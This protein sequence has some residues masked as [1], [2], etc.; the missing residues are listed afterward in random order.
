[1]STC[2]LCDKEKKLLKK[3][4]IISDFFYRQGNLYDGHHKLN[5]I[6]VLNFF[7]GVFKFSRQS[8]GEYDKN[9]LCKECDGVVIKQYEDYTRKALY[10]GSL[11]DSENPKFKNIKQEGGVGFTSICD[12]NYNKF[13]LCI[14]S[15]L[16]RAHHSKREFFKDI[17]LTDIQEKQIKQY[18]KTGK[19]S[20]D[21]EWS[22]ICFTYLNDKKI[23][24]DLIVQ[25]NKVKNSNYILFTFLING[26]F[27]LIYDSDKEIPEPIKDCRIKSDNTM[28]VIHVP[29]GKGWDF[30]K[31]FCGIN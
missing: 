17:S 13:K 31:L 30:I 5:R 18:I 2:K 20:S 29:K 7:K 28:K 26:Y 25:P 22:I 12:L 11:A 24:K 16:W 3:S 23:S 1:M 27:F 8:S 4:H 19:C 14:L 9:I 21:N 6:S 10:G 15:I